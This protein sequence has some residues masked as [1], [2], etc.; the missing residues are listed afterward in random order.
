MASV[1]PSSGTP[2][3][4][5][6]PPLRALQAFDAVVRNKNVVA[7]AESLH[8]TPGAVSQQIRQLEE[9]LGVA[10]FDRESTGLRP[11]A[12][13]QLYHE[14]VARGFECFHAAHTALEAA[15]HGLHLTLSTFPSVAT[16]WFASRLDKWHTLSPGVR[17][18]VEATDREPKR[19]ESN[20]DVRMTYGTP[21]A[22]GAHHRLLFTDR[23]T[24]VCSPSLLRADHPIEQPADLLHYPL[25]HVEWGWNERSPPTWADWLRAAGVPVPDTLAP[26]T[27]SLSGMAVDA[28]LRGRGVSLGQ[29]LFTADS[30]TQGLL[31]AP[32]RISLPMPYPYYLV[33]QPGA[34]EAPDARQFLD[35]LTEEAAQTQRDINA[36]FG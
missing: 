28:T 31:I 3:M 22:D 1:P 8:V 21:P 9:F 5:R 32:F 4:N 35:W 23:V 29:G 10:L 26:L 27:Y 2:K 20:W 18:H 30:L 15:Q 36:I 6:L 33:W 13:G 11:T 34:L 19:G 24:P 7:A 12:L 17:V 16:H 25:V 14:H